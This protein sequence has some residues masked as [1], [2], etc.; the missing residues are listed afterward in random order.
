M[1]ILKDLWAV[2]III[3]V[4]I[5]ICATALNQRYDAIQRYSS[6]E[7]TI[8]RNDIV[9]DTLETFIQFQAEDI[10]AYHNREMN[11]LAEIERLKEQMQSGVLPPLEVNE[12]GESVELQDGQHNQSETRSRISYPERPDRLSKDTGMGCG[13]DARERFSTRHS[14]FVSLQKRIR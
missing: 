3:L 14:R 8:G 10:G 6:A 9:I 7:L 1:R 11:L 2:I 5:A 4:L 12:N 13:S